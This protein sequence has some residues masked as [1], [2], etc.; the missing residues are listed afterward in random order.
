[1]NHAL[2]APPAE[3]PTAPVPTGRPRTRSLPLLAIAGV[4]WMLL[5]PL[6]ALAAD[7]PSDAV[8]GHWLTEEGSKGGRARVEV[9]RTEDGEIVG[10]IVWLEEPRFPPGEP[11]AGEPKVDLENPD[12][13]K[14][15]RPVLGL[16]ILSG[17]TYEGD[18]LWSGGTIYDPANG[19]TY[20][21]R[22]SLDSAEDDTLDLRGYVGIPLFGR[23]TTWTRVEAPDEDAG[24]G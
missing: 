20:K 11:M 1:M 14:R 24:S 9:S 6:P 19:K 15:D 17:F 7:L 10:E 2:E 4:L 8:T 18:G 3:T 13:E 12:P 21:A 23:T 16:E 5:A 22:M